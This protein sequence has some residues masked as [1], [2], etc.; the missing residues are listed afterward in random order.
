MEETSEMRICG[1]TSL[2]AFLGARSQ[3]DIEVTGLNQAFIQTKFPARLDLVGARSH[4][5]KLPILY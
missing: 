5:P 3:S 1:K 2:M 4:A